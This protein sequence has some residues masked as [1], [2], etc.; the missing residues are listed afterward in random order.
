MFCAQCGFAAQDDARFCRSCGS[1]IG[2]TAPAGTPAE[3][4]AY[5]PSAGAQTAATLEAP[6][7]RPAGPGAGT[8]YLRANT[9]PGAD[10]AVQP[11][12]RSVIYAGF[13]RRFAAAFVDGVLIWI[14]T[15]IVVFAIAFV[16]EL[17]APRTGLGTGLATAAA[18]AIGVLYYPLLESSK[19]QAT[20]GKRALGIMVTG[21]QG[22]R[23]SFWQALGRSL[24]KLISALLL[25]FGYLMAAFTSRKQALHDMMAGTLVV[26]GTPRENV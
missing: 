23:I 3:P 5:R 4:A 1:P 26:V 12:V 2:A 22:E 13:W 14:V 8:T 20:W 7:Y 6:T 19:A 21:L 16:F 10:T 17:A 15:F 11:T 18:L 25:C 9:G 24:A